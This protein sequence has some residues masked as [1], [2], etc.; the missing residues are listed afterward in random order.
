MT[1]TATAN[2]AGAA[3]QADKYDASVLVAD[4]KKNALDVVRVRLTR[5]KNYDLLDIRQFYTDKA[6]ELQPTGKGLTIRQEQIP[7]LLAALQKAAD[8]VESADQAE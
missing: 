7:E 2:K 8:M 6:D 5:F 4:I 1:T 3:Q